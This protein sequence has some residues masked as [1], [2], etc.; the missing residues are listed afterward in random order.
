MENAWTIPEAAR[1]SIPNQVRTSW[2]RKVPYY[3]RI[4]DHFAS[5]IETGALGPGMK[6]PPERTLSDEFRITRV[7]VRQALMQLEAEGLVVFH[8]HRG[9]VVTT[10]SLEEIAELQQSIDNSPTETLQDAAVKLRRLSVCVDSGR[11]A[12]LLGSA[13]AAVERVVER[14]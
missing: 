9:A 1:W 8:A 12:R 4:R 11:P 3:L 6:L 2:D 7:T 5:L 13:L 10:L 14:A